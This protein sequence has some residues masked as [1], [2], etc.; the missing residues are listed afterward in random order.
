[1]VR[2]VGSG[3]RRL[4]AVIWMALCSLVC[5]ALGEALEA[6]AAL[7]LS[8]Y[9]ASGGVVVALTA[10]FWVP[11]RRVCAFAIAAP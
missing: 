1:M 5:E 9:A 7:R 6:I 2:R 11:P 3:T 4:C 10:G 8:W